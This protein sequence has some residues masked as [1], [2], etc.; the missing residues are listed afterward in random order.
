MP[1]YSKTVIYK[2]QHEDNES[3]VYIGSTTDFTKRKCSHKRSCNNP[4]V[5]NIKL[6]QMIRDNGGWN[7]FKMIQIKEFP[8]NNKREAEAE[9]DRN[10]LELK[11]NMNER[12]ASRSYAE[13][14]ID[15]RDKISE[16]TK[17]YYTDNRDKI[18]ENSKQY[19]NNN[20]DKYLEKQKQYYNDNLDK[21]LER[22]KQYHVNNRDKILEKKKQYRVNNRDKILER[23]TCECGSII[24]KKHIQTHKR[25]KKHIDL[26]KQSQ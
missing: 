13:W 10:M 22:N 3:L 15:N 20:R 16:R 11:A 4:K 17:Q 26:L 25:T 5:F 8:C 9:E 6:Y 19:Y 12:R 1:D 7:C 23:I 21:I 14:V 24:S 2:I 18:L